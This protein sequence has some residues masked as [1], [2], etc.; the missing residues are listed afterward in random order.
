M[1]A[2]ITCTVVLGVLALWQARSASHWRLVSKLLG[3]DIAVERAKRTAI[4]MALCDVSEGLK[5]GDAT[6]CSQA[7]R[8]A[9]QAANDNTDETLRKLGFKLPERPTGAV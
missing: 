2:G 6:L 8:A 9:L 3:H 4:A 1:I 7:M 5:R